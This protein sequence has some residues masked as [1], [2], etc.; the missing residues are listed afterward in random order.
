MFLT[1]TLRMKVHRPTRHKE[2]RLQWLWSHWGQTGY[3]IHDSMRLRYP[4]KRVLNGWVL[5]EAKSFV[6][7]PLSRVGRW[8][9]RL[10]IKKGERINIPLRGAPAHEIL[11]GSGL[12]ICNSELVRRGR[13]FFVHLTLKM[14]VSPPPILR[15][16]VLAVDLGERVVATSVAWDGMQLD[17]PRFHARAVR[18]MR[19]HHGWLHTRLRELRHNKAL[20]KIGSSEHRKVEDALQKAASALVEQA[21]R[22][23]A[24]IVVGDLS[25]IRKRAKR[26]KRFRRIVHSMP[27]YRLTRILEY[28]A[29][30]HG[31][32]MLRIG[33]HY[34]SIEC[35]ICNERGERPSQ[36]R[37][38]CPHCGDYNADL[39]GAANLAKR[40]WRHVREVGALGFEPEGV[41]PGFHG[42]AQA[43]S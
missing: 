36:G 17:E 22:L 32:P 13:H 12:K 7:T 2:A 23:D 29:A 31:V 11:L 41:A 18:G 42:T 40:T 20:A 43:V 16:R 24:L 34:S 10:P 28:K 27:Y 15:S 39:N 14:E 38:R 6:S 30:W 4:T 5:S 37:F 9:L 21:V 1:K 3:K 35:H 25:G 19:R 26:S 33:E 8:W